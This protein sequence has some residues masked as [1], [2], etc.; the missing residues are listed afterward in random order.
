MCGRRMHFHVAVAGAL[1]NGQVGPSPR[2]TKQ[3]LNECFEVLVPVVAHIRHHITA[4]RCLVLHTSLLLWL[5]GDAKCLKP[6]RCNTP[7]AHAHFASPRHLGVL[8]LLGAQRSHKRTCTASLLNEKGS[9]CGKVL[10]QSPLD[11][12]LRIVGGNKAVYG[13]HPWLVSLKF[14]GEHFCGASILNDK[15][16]LCAAH[17]FSSLAKQS[18]TYVLIV[19][20]E[21]DQRTLD[22]GEQRLKVKNVKIHK[23]FMT[24]NAV[25][26]DIAVV[27][28]D[29]RITF[30]NYTQPICLPLPSEEFKPGTSCVVSGW[31]RL[32]ERG[33]LPDIV[34]EVQLNLID[35][36]TCSNVI[37]TVR[38]NKKLFS[39]L[40][41]GPETGEKDACQGDSGGPMVCPRKNGQW[42]LVGVTSWGKGCGRSWIDNASKQMSNR[43]SPGVFTD[44]KQFLPWILGNMY[45]DT[46]PNKKSASSKFTFKMEVHSISI[47]SSASNIQEGNTRIGSN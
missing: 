11:Q 37:S 47:T 9:K 41:A 23:D 28:V 46:Q 1:V 39:V 40:C 31:G 34:Q 29:G 42:T 45:T 20:G 3:S 30:G 35:P 43:G 18:L 13:S 19:V 21:Y 6:A 17:C 38:P 32:K 26:N 14:K 2:W 16:L 15:W 33:P 44:V 7:S 27:E 8:M 22:A 36:R 10:V 24:S 25:I 12:S 5:T 4:W